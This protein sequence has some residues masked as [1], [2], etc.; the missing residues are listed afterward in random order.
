MSLKHALL[1]FLS[2]QPLTGY[3]LKKAFDG[4][5]SNFWPADQAQIY[6]TLAGLTTDGLAEVRIV[7]QDGRPDRKEHVITQAGLDELDRWLR[8]PLDAQATREPFLLKVYFAG[9]LT[10][11]E[12]LAVIDER[13]AEG[14]IEMDAFRGI[15]AAYA[16]A[17]GEGPIPLERWLPMATLVNG[18]RHFTT[19]LDWLRELRAQIQDPS[20]QVPLAWSRFTGELLRPQGDLP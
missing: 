6:R 7:P 19:E 13:I 12:F 5:V 18:V 15:V 20:A 10:R 8:T 3:D 14:E 9:R 16:A 2:L 11:D 4:S 1:G 17:V